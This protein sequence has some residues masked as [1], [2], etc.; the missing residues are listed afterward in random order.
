M[1]ISPQFLQRN[2]VNVN[3]SYGAA[4]VG[5]AVSKT[6]CGPFTWRGSFRP[7]NVESR[8]MGVFQDGQFGKG[9]HVVPDPN[10][11]FQ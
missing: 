9:P 1:F 6:P 8:D 2:E 4:Q 7:L 10:N 5:V 11:L 3:R